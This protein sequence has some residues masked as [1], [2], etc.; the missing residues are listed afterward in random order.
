M[1]GQIVNALTTA[2][3]YGIIFAENSSESGYTSR[4]DFCLGFA[5][6]AERLAAE[7]G[8]GENSDRSPPRWAL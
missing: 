2:H 5:T 6:G 1:V 8:H 3:C 7:L 4:R